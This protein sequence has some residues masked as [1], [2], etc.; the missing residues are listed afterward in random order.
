MQQ[1][2]Q[3]LKRKQA[4]AAKLAREIE[5]LQQAEEKLREIAPLLAEGGEEEEG[6]LLVEVE[7]EVSTASAEDNPLMAA[8]EQPAMNEPEQAKA[9]ALR[10]P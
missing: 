5:M 2:R 3:V 9:V 8:P 6:S 4:Q 1:I 7:D 10:W